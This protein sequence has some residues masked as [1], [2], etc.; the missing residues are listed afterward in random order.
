M[1]LLIHHRPGRPPDSRHPFFCEDQVISPTNIP[2]Y[3]RPT[4]LAAN[5]AVADA[6][7]GVPMDIMPTLAIAAAV[8]ATKLAMLGLLI[9]AL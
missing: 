9:H 2:P 5:A 1:R 4:R 8:I 6:A 7:T 3:A